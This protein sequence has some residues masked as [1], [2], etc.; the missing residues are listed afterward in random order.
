MREEIGPERKLMVDANQHLGR[1]RGDRGDGSRSKPFNPLWIEEPTQPRRRPRPRGDRTGGRAESASRPANTAPNRIMFKQL[2]QSDA[3]AFCQVD[4]C[5]L[6]G[7]NEVLAVLLHGRQ[8]RRAGLPA[9]RWRRPVRVRPAPLD[10]RLRRGERVSMEGRVIE[11]V[12][13][14]HEHFEH[15][16]VIENGRYMPPTAPGYSITIKPASLD[17][18]RISRTERPGPRRNHDKARGLGRGSAADA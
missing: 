10:L 6:G 15:P 5:R 17:Q 9:R 18:V 3:I 11:Y 1:R 12:D 4:S 14:L 7:V 16:V 2:L 8:V 13:H